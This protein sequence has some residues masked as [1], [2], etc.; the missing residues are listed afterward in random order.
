[1]NLNEYVMV[2][3]IANARIC[4]ELI[5]QYNTENLHSAT[6]ATATGDKVVKDHRLCD[7]V[8]IDDQR[9]D[10]IVWE[11][12]DEYRRRHPL[13]YCKTQTE[14]QFLRYGPGGK[15]EEHVD[16][17]AKAPRT[18][19]VSIILND[20][21]TGGEFMFFNKELIIKPTVGD[22]IMFPSNFM[23]PHGV[24]PVKFGTRFAVV[25]WLN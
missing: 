2:L 1:M 13:M 19:S 6:S 25:N 21:Y 8:K 16:T 10:D 22:V 15:F 9:V 5:N 17:Y 3:P 23:F 18:I 12:H 24:M 20:D 7:T 4:K 14:S 11:A